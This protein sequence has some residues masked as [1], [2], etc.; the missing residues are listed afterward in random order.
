M[1]DWDPEL[2]NRF[3][4]YRAEPFEMILERLR[5]N[6]AERVIDLGCGS[7][8]NTA[9]LARRAADSV[10]LGIDSS[11]AMI[12]S[13]LKLRD[14]LEPELRDRLSFERRD[15]RELKA[16]VEYSLV[17]S[18]AAIQWLA[19]HRDVFVR[20]YRAL[21]PGGRLVVQM[22]ANDGETA[23]ATI[24]AMALEEPWRARL[25]GLAPPSRTV[26]APENYA[27]MLGEI[28]FADVN[29]HYHTFRHPMVSPGEVVEWIRA[30]ALRP[31]LDALEVPAR[32]P[33]ITALTARLERA[34]G[35]RGPLIFNFRRLFIWARRPEP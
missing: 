11:P 23:Q 15:I 16:T 20:C 21:V 18:N 1:V 34:Y 30:T 28:G 9:E 22:P 6:R 12:E 14:S 29:C 25:S 10:V 7:G 31:F 24:S 27:A 13:A 19:D 5:L 8:E 4:R 26:A 32:E 35:T 2:Y 3:R 33:F 17:F